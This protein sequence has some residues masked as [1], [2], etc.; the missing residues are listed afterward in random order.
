[1]TT[2][3]YESRSMSAPVNLAG[4][5]VDADGFRGLAA[6]LP[7]A[8]SV[9]TTTEADGTPVGMTSGTV[10]SLSCE[11]PLL[12][13]CIG[14]SSRTLRTITDSRR[15]CVNV[16]AGDGAELSARFAGRAED[17]FAGVG[18]HRGPSGNPVLDE[19]VSAWLEC[20]LYQV[21]DG[22]DHAIVIGLVTEGQASTCAPLVYFRRSYA[23]FAPGA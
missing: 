14:R 1:M 7:T 15:F 19:A 13:V 17:K 6:S 8:V 3:L 12:L 20:E 2:A 22:G 21:V 4:Y 9:V 11:P 5:G 10:C 18:W 23:G 16:L